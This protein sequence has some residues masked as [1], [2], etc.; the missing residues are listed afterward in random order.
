MKTLNTLA[1]VALALFFAAAVQA[2]TVVTVSG[3]HLCCGACFKAVDKAVDGVDGATATTDK[4]AKTIT[5]K[6]GDDET[7]QKALNALAIA[8]FHGSTDND[9]LGFKDVS[10]LAGGQVKRLALTGVHNCCGGCNRAIKRAIASVDGVVADTAKPNA[11]DVVVEGDFDA[12]AV[13]KALNKVGFHV[14]VKD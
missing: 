13:V 10:G 2:E 4:K 5:I 6:A 14:T 11:K 3:S 9:K 12:A 7:A 8:G 1:G